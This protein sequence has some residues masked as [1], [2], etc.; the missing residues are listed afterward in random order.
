[1][2]FPRGSCGQDR[3]GIVVKSRPPALESEG[4]VKDEA[5]SR[6]A[7]R[8]DGY[9]L[10]VV[11]GPDAGGRFEVQG[12]QPPV[13]VGQGAACNVRLSDRHASRRHAVFEVTERGLRV[14]DLDT[15]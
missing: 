1:M 6:L 9:A 15:T 7:V 10:V 5:A 2:G 13:L 11:E 8:R 4:T 14:T 3:R 12:S